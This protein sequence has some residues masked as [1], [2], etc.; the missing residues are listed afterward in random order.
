[1]RFND[2]IARRPVQNSDNIE[3]YCKL[4]RTCLSFT[5]TINK[6]TTIAN[7]IEHIK[8]IVQNTMDVTSFSLVSLNNNI[9]EIAE[10][11]PDI[12]ALDLPIKSEMSS[13]TSKFT[14]FYIRATITC[15]VCLELFLPN[16]NSRCF[17]CMHNFCNQCIPQLMHDRIICPMLCYN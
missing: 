16:R 12:I 8:P 5:V 17:G 11:G 10:D 6:N 3:I 13:S 7:F 1:M 14:A 2:F 4:A 15:P 9:N